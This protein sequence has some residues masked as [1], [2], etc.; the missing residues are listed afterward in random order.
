MPY[1]GGIELPIVVR[2]TGTAVARDCRYCRRQQFSMDRGETTAPAIAVTWYATGSFRVPVDGASERLV[3]YA[4]TDECPRVVLDGIPQTAIADSKWEA[5][6]ACRDRFG[7]CFR[8]RF[9]DGLNSGVDVWR[10]PIL[11][12]RRHAEPPDW[13]TWLQF[14]AKVENRAWTARFA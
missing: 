10:E 8:F 1:W 7:T 13:T 5:A 12:R 2:N 4:T 9:L 11:I 14:P 6:I 3:A